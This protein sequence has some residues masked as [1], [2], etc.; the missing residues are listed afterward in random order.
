MTGATGMRTD[1]GERLWDVVVVGAGLAG[2]MVALQ[3]SRRGCEVLLLERRPFPRWKV[4]GACL[5][6]AAQG[7]LAHAGLDGLVARAGA[8][9][10]TELR[11]TGWGR[12]AYVALQGSVALSREALDH[13]LVQAAVEGGVVFAQGASAE[14]GPMRDGE[15]T[16]MVRGGD[17]EQSVRARVVVSAAGLHGL[18][19]RALAGPAPSPLFSRDPEW[20]WAPCWKAAALVMVLVWCTWWWGPG[21]TWAWCARRITA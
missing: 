18:R 21:D 11:M 3:L 6:G 10:L 20:G 12:T 9:R 1:L 13:A 15:R 4:C 14:L 5:N 8:P 7:A 2:A 19:S 17:G 16:L